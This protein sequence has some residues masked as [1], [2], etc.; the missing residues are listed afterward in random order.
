VYAGGQFTQAGGEFRNRVA[1]IRRENAQAH[2]WNPDANNTVRAIFRTGDAIYVGGDFTTLG[3]R[4]HAYFAA[5]SALP[6]FV[7][8]TQEWTPG[9]PFSSQIISGDGARLIVEVT[10]SFDS[11]T[12]VS[13][14]ENLNGSPIS[15]T[16]DSATGQQGRYY[17][18]V[19]ETE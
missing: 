17:R 8:G 11:W 12:A 6:V 19:L 3:G 15:F 16:D 9:G 5:F 1:G 18:A 7:P 13:T 2:D 14:N 10:T 4:Q